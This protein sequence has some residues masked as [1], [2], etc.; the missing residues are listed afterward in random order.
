MSDV[1][2]ISGLARELAAEQSLEAVVRHGLAYL[3]RAVGVQ[4]GAFFLYD[5]RQGELRMVGSRGL[6]LSFLR[7]ASRQKVAAGE[8]GPAPRAAYERRMVTTDTSPPGLVAYC[9]GDEL[10]ARRLAATVAVPLVAADRALGVVQLFAPAGSD[11]SPAGQEGFRALCDLLAVVLEKSQLVGERDR[12]LQISRTLF[13]LSRTVLPVAEVDELLPRIVQS[14][15][16]LLGGSC[17]CIAAWQ[18][19][20]RTLSIRASLNLPDDFV[21]RPVG[22]GQ[23]LLGRVMA[24]NQPL[25][26]HDYGAWPEAN[27]ALVAQGLASVVG[28]PLRL[29]REAVGV[30]AVG[31]TQPAVRFTW[32]DAEML[33]SFAA[34]AAIALANASLF[35]Q[36]RLKA[37]QM[38]ALL[39]IS[40]RLTE[41]L[42]LD[43]VL[44][45]VLQEATFFLDATAGALHLAGDG[46]GLAIAGTCGPADL[47][48]PAEGLAVR[49]VAEG[50][51]V[52]G[53]GDGRTYLA[54][55]LVAGAKRIG[56]LTCVRAGP[57]TFSE[58]DL[59]FLWTLAGH[60]A[61][62]IE[63][64]RLHEE[65]EERSVRDALTGL[66]NVRRLQARL[67]EEVLRAERYGRELSFLMLDIDR[68][69]RYNDTYGHLQ[70]DRVLRQVADTVSRRV[71]TVDQ[72]FRYGGEEICVLLP[73][74]PRAQA[75]LVAERIRLAVAGCPA[76]EG[77]R[78]V[79]R[80][81]V[82]IGV[83]SFPGDAAGPRELIARADEALYRAKAQ[84]RNRVAAAS[85]PE[86]AGNGQER[87]VT[88]SSIGR[89]GR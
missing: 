74:T 83:A 30:L 84:G 67:S 17:G 41:S 24:E 68:F 87:I 88:T 70:G 27:P 20:S 45:S 56:A 63:N 6:P 11:L 3:L 47:L 29:E 69:K 12:S 14:A 71:R 16:R 7:A 9:G 44:T 40:R 60:A 79:G 50:E 31:T 23:G 2:L 19:A 58:D 86:Q 28:V 52:T 55:P 80:V 10:S 8:A 13:D 43:A 85:P 34:S 76:G 5:E 89:R 32:D 78:D 4:A 22:P 51:P 37:D 61:M 33:A 26:V 25:L 82:S 66:Y 1:E 54:V 73:E 36:I 39:K 75:L 35:R 59:A 77:D 48:P 49:A 15:V 53:G 72:V 57:D 42:K 18:D 62:A 21:R 65:A 46:G 64:A 38:A 81:T